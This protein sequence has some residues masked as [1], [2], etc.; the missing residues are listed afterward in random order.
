MA[1]CGFCT[2]G[3]VIAMYARLEEKNFAP[4]Q[5]DMESCLDGN[6]CRCTGYRPLLDA[7]KSFATD[8]E[9]QDFVGLDSAKAGTG[10]LDAET[11][12]RRRPV[13]PAAALTSAMAQNSSNNSIA[14]TGSGRTWY[15]PKTIQDAADIV[16]GLDPADVKLVS[17]NTS[18]GVFKRRGGLTHPI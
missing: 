4:L 13:F 16:K 6:L 3:A 5:K 18:S 1:Q 12:Q 11:F 14:W 2:P 9:T 7:A 17:G 15:R 8:S 10:A